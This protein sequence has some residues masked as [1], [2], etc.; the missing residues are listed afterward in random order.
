MGVKYMYTLRR[1]G[2]LKHWDFILVD[3]LAL[4][5]A[6]F[7]ACWIHFGTPNFFGQ[8]SLVTMF[9]FL[10]LLNLIAIIFFHTLTGVLRR[11]NRYEVTGILKQELIVG[12]L[13]ISI[14]YFTHT[15][16][17][18]SRGILL[19]VGVI[20]FFY[21]LLGR[22]LLKRELRQR[23]FDDSGPN[24]LIVTSSP[25]AE[26]VITSLSGHNYNMYNLSGVILLD[27]DRVG[28][29][30]LGVPVVANDEGCLE[31]ITRNWIDEIFLVPG[32]DV[33]F[34]EELYNDLLET[35]L[36]VHVDLGHMY[37]DKGPIRIVE[38]LGDFTVM[39]TSLNYMT[40]G[41]AIWKRT[42]DILIGLVGTGLTGIITVFLGPSIYIKSPGPIFFSQERV[43]Q[44][45]KTFKMYKF[46]SMDLNAEEKKKELMAQN[47][48]SD[49]LMFKMDFDPRII[50]NEILPDGT[51]K[52]G[53]GEFIRKTS[54]D[55]FPQFWNVL[56]GDMSIIGTRPPTMDEWNKYELYHRS[57]LVIKPGL[58]GMWQVSGRSEITDFEEVVKLDREYIMDWSPLLDVKIFFKTIQTVLKREGSM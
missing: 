29:K 35:G 54:L 21:D 38:N 42:M 19:Y 14:L 6:Y 43:G 22:Y 37:G 25:R 7:T 15:S 48:V 17:A 58:T 2:W 9:W 36:T 8:S 5:L 34:N 24:L 4:V 49:G 51:K 57:R 27:K 45:G 50:G 12:T 46:R 52:T 28:E 26:E 23:M 1:Q 3:T 41:Q 55:E 32:P 56:K 47:R 18:Y 39:T 30:I 13:F 11:R 16:E 20:Y 40:I 31:Y 33:E 44:N 10:I 53:I